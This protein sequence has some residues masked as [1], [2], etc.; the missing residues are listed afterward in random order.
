MQFERDLN[1]GDK[2]TVIDIITEKPRIRKCTIV[3]VYRYF[4]LADF[5]AYLEAINRGNL[6]CHAAR[7]FYGWKGEG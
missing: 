4:I 5:G 2:L 3:K 6:I 7:I 1:K